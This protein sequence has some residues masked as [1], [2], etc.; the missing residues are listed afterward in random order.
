MKEALQKE[1][2]KQEKLELEKQKKVNPD[3]EKPANYKPKFD[4]SKP[5]D[6]SQYKDAAQV[7]V[8]TVDKGTAQT[9]GTIYHQM[10]VPV[11]LREMLPMV[12]PV[13]S[14]LC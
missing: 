5:L 7:A 12:S 14:A 1:N 10:L 6:P 13:C 3:L 2:M 11:A 9:I 8:A 4:L